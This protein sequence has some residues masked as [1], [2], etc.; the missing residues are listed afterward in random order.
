MCVWNITK[1]QNYSC[2]SIS[3]NAKTKFQQKEKINNNVVKESRWLLKLK[4][5]STSEIY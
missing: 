2:N 3:Q 5:H 4:N 1:S